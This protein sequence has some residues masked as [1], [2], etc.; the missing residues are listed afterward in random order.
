MRFRRFRDQSNTQ[1]STFTDAQ[2][3]LRNIQQ[4]LINYRTANS[5]TYARDADPLALRQLWRKNHF[6][7]R[8]AGVVETQPPS[9]GEQTF[10]F[11]RAQGLCFQ[12]CDWGP[13][14]PQESPFNLG[15]DTTVA[16]GSSEAYSSYFFG[17]EECDKVI[18]SK[19][20]STVFVFGMVF[21]LFWMGFFFLS[22][23]IVR[24]VG[25]P[26]HEMEVWECHPEDL[27]NKNIM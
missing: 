13:I 10:V 23:G 22:R 1:L 17:V 26:G 6:C 24:S 16:T 5:I 21:W 19:C 8:Q 9:G 14:D 25:T 15:S 11:K 4:V 2:V 3:Y 20:Y 7:S 12:H 27:V 18:F